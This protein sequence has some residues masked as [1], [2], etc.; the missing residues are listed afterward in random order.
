MF[1]EKNSSTI[2]YFMDNTKTNTMPQM[3][4]I[5]LRHEDLRNQLHESSNKQFSASM[6]EK[7]LSV[8]KTLMRWNRG[9]RSVKQ[10][11]YEKDS[12]AQQA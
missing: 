2:E 3:E 9:S 6:Y 7:S 8:R 1:F 10:K 4:I 5:I 11:S 12:T